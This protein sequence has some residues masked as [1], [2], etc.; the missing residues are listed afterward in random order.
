MGLLSAARTHAGV[1]AVGVLVLLGGGA[2]TAAVV[3]SPAASTEDVYEAPEPTAPA[4]TDAPA[5]PEPSE[6][7]PQPSDAP[8]Q[9]PAAT[10]EHVTEAEA[11][12]SQEPSTEPQPDPA[13]APAPVGRLP[14][15]APGQDPEGVGVI[16]EDGYYTPAP[17]RPN[18]GEPLPDESWYTRGDDVTKMPG[19]PGYVP[20]PSD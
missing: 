7:A 18:P 5:A 16:G 11:P 4:T 17:P 13:P 8:P 9:T 12:A 1:T 15:L 3:T 6:V 2:A 14:E 10:L 20:P 19:E